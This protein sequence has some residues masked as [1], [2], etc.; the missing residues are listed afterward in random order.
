MKLKKFIPFAM[1][2]FLGLSVANQGFSYTSSIVK[3]DNPHL[4]SSGEWNK[5]R[6][7]SSKIDNEIESLHRRC[8]MLKEK[9]NGRVSPDEIKALAASIKSGI[10]EV[11]NEVN[12]ELSEGHLFIS[13]SRT[14]MGKIDTVRRS[15]ESL[16]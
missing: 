14:F 4:L 2:G 1:A 7:L 13:D 3:K 12:S 11:F 15:L 5:W 16:G 8:N 9:Q 6:V 10:E